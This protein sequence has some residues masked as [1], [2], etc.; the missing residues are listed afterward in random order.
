MKMIIHVDLVRRFRVSGAKW[1][2]SNPWVPSL[3]A[4]RQICLYR[5]LK[6]WRITMKPVVMVHYGCRAGFH[7]LHRVAAGCVADISDKH[8]TSIVWVE[9]NV[10]GKC[11]VCWAGGTSDP[12]EGWRGKC[13]FR[14][15]TSS[16]KGK[17][18]EWSLLVPQVSWRSN[19]ILSVW[20]SPQPNC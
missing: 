4:Q 15:N 3:R 8:A 16:A 6:T 11:S 20:R 10:E 14:T 18:Q 1:Y 19:C 9:E 17:W 2:I 7:F 13:S 12:W 5:D